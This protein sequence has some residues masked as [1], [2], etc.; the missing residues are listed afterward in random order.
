MI[1]RIK[2]DKSATG[3]V[4]FGD[5][6]LAGERRVVFSG[7]NDVLTEK[8]IGVFYEVYNELGFGFLES[9]YRKATLIGL[10]QAGFQVKA[11]VRSR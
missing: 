11:E 4:D 2:T 7:A 10:Q 5:D 8:I 9:V 6:A 1:K 3:P